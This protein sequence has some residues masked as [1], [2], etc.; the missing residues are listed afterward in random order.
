MIQNKNYKSPPSFPVT[1]DSHCVSYSNNYL[2]WPP[3]YFELNY[4][5]AFK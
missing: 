4:K 3:S 5:E 1:I 2:H